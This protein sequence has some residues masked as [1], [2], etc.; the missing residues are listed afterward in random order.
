MLASHLTLQDALS[1]NN[2]PT[3]NPPSVDV[4]PELDRLAVALRGD[5]HRG[6]DVD[7]FDGLS[8]LLRTF[9]RGPAAHF[10]VINVDA[11][12]ARSPDE[13]VQLLLLLPQGRRLVLNVV[14]AVETALRDAKRVPSSDFDDF[15]R[16]VAAA[17]RRVGA[18]VPEAD[19]AVMHSQSYL[20]RYL[21]LFDRVTTAAPGVFSRTAVLVSL[22]GML[23]MARLSPRRHFDETVAFMREH[24]PELSERLLNEE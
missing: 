21:P 23:W 22:S 7:V 9:N 13:C 5:G 15:C 16:L 10:V 1:T 19:R 6:A 11:L 20:A 14:V 4:S 18:A 8:R 24:Q 3:N 17:I 12:K 2:P